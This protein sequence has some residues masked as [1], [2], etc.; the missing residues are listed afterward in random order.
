MRQY[1]DFV[2][3]TVHFTLDGNYHPSG[4]CFPCLFPG[5]SSVTF[6]GACNIHDRCYGTYGNT[7]SYCDNKMRTL[8]K[9]RCFSD[10][11]VWYLPNC[12]NLKLPACNDVADIY[13]LAVHELGDDAYIAAQEIASE[14]FNPTTH[15]IIRGGNAILPQPVPQPEPLPPDA[16]NDRVWPMPGIQPGD[17][18]LVTV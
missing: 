17:G 13:W 7:K 9:N 8:M 18:D 1:L 16:P 2:P 5:E 14:C 4:L 12:L 15:E 3:D 6:T 10:L 11:S